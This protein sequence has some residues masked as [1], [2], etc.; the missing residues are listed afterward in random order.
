MNIANK[1]ALSDFDCPFKPT[2]SP[3]VHE[4]HAEVKQWA[5][6]FQL[7]KSD[8]DQDDFEKLRV[9]WLICRAFH[10]TEKERILLSAKFTF[11]LYKVDDL[12]DKQ[13]SGKDN[14]KTSKMVESFCEILALNR[15][16]DLDIGTPLESAL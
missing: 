11:W 16:V 7:I 13:Q 3:I 15:M 8:Q 1:Y 2:L 5:K 12:F 6:K 10:D 4:I 14:E 9:A